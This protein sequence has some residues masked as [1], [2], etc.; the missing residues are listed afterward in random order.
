MAIALGLALIAAAPRDSALHCEL[1]WVR[2]LA[3]GAQAFTGSGRDEAYQQVRQ[4]YDRGIAQLLLG[5][6]RHRRSLAA[7][8]YNRARLEEARQEGDVLGRAW[9][10]YSCALELVPR[11][12]YRTRLKRLGKAPVV[13]CI[14]RQ[15]ARV[16]REQRKAQLADAHGWSAFPE[17][18]GPYDNESQ[19]LRAAAP[20]NHRD[21]TMCSGTS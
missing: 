8:F 5:P 16:Q 17:C 18:C 9:Q 21:Y 13:S 20:L 14:Q 11:K 7:C 1:G 4:H 2:F 12:A 10:D 3:Q 19:L 6:A 15:R